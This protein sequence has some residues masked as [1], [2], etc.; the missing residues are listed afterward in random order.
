M[1]KLTLDTIVQ[2]TAVGTDHGARLNAQD[3]TSQ[4]EAVHSIR[5]P[6]MPRGHA[7]YGSAAPKQGISYSR[8]GRHLCE[9]ASKLIHRAI[10]SAS[11]RGKGVAS[12]AV[13][14]VTMR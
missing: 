6:A 14:P 2:V 7:S 9:V 11:S 4:D 12:A 10:F 1:A 5:V 3:H 8:T 13:A